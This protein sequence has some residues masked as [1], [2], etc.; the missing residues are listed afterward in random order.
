MNET[1][2]NYYFIDR[3]SVDDSDMTD[4]GT[5]IRYG[6]DENYYE[7]NRETGIGYAVSSWDE[8]EGVG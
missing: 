4:D 3:N 5:V 8:S 6:D 7:F 2:F 1:L